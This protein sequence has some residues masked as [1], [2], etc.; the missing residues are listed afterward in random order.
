MKKW[1]LILFLFICACPIMAQNSSDDMSAI[2]SH[3]SY[4]EALR[5]STVNNHPKIQKTYNPGKLL[6]YLPLYGYQRLVSEQVSASCC[7]EPS[8]S[9]FSILSIKKLGILKGLFLTADRLTRCNGAA[10]LEA[11]PYLYDPVKAKVID[12]PEMYKSIH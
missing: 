2:Q 9:A 3:I 7:F 4:A 5:S 12:E 1:T 10:D 8:C 11:E 6:L